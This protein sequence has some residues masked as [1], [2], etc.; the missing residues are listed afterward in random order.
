M[1]LPPEVLLILRPEGRQEV[2][3]V[4]NNVDERINHSQQGSMAACSKKAKIKIWREIQILK[5]RPGKNFVPIQAHTGI[6][7]WW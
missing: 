3:R 4:H 7:V 5:N 1:F 6:I 2:V